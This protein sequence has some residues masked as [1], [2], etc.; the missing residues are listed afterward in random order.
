MEAT[1]YRWDTA[2]EDNPIPLLNRRKILG[3]QML[4]A[5]VKLSKGCHVDVH[6][7]VSEQI[8]VILSGRVRWTFVRENGTTEYVEAGAGEVGV[9]P[10]N[11]PHGVDALEDTEILDIL[12]PIAPMGVDSQTKDAHTMAGIA[13]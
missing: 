13:D 2:D 6:S 5:R 7:H 1:I 12:T 3:E 4:L 10:S 8:A 11:V 9:M